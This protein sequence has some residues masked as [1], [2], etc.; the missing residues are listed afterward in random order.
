MPD[1]TTP[2]KIRFKLFWPWPGHKVMMGIDAGWQMA[3]SQAS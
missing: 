1:K 3:L 2:L